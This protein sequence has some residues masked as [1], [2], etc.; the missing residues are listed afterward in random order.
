MGEFSV[1]DRLLAPSS[2]KMSHATHRLSQ[3]ISGGW[4]EGISLSFVS[5][6]D[7]EVGVWVAS[8]RAVSARDLIDS[9]VVSVDAETSV[10]EACEVLMTENIPCLV[11]KSNSSDASG[12]NIYQGLFDYSDVNAF[13]TLAATRHTYLPDDL[14]GNARVDNIVAAAKAGRVPVHLVSNL[15]EKNQLETL[16]N[17]ANIISLL[18]TFAKGSHRV[19]IHSATEPGEF[20]GMISDRR[21]LSWFASYAKESPSF[22]KYLSNP[23]Q[24]L[25]L[26]SLNLY[27]AVV[28]ATSTASILDAMRLMSEE[29][30]SSIAVIEENRGILLSAVSVTDI[31]KIVV[32]HQNNQILTTALHHFVSQIKELDGSTD[33]AD[34]YPVYSV[35]PSSTLSYTVEKLLATNAHRLFVTKESRAASPVLSSNASSNLSGIVSIVDILSLFA[36]LANVP[37]VDPTHMQRHRR[38]SSASSQSSK[39]E[40]DLF[41]MGLSRSSSRSSVR[42]SPTIVASSPPT[43]PI[44][45]SGRNAFPSLDVKR[46]ESLRKKDSV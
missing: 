37:G 26:P 24:L 19:L 9:R 23:I 30:V 21:V 20:I 25:S 4:R 34:R 5:P 22:Q 28:A 45:D 40:R 29:G 33:G 10:E 17:D 7:D 35:S 39:S 1:Y 13:L 38:A 6:V 44:P 32:P 36:R 42:R 15:S 8:W 41:L 27:S 12:S 31:G 18:E 16:P 3:S 14:R 11:I 2:R 43:M 46:G